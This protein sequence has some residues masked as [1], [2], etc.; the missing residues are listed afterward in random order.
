MTT[1]L[2][3]RF[4]R[5]RILDSTSFQLPSPYADTYKGHGGGGSEAGVKIQLEYDLISGEFLETHVG[6]AV[7]NDCRYGQKRTQTLDPGEVSLRDLRYFS[8]DVQKRFQNDKHFM[9]QGFVGIH[10]SIKKEKMVLKDSS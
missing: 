2:V 5:I 9:Y 4:T 10:K 3:N 1:F 7:S 8:M 6:N